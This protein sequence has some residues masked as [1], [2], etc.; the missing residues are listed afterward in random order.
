MR[1]LLCFFVLA[2][3]WT[4][5]P[6][7]TTAY[8]IKSGLVLGSQKWDN[9]FDR[10]ILAKY[11]AA[12]AIETVDEEED[13]NALFVQLGYHVKGS[14][15]RYRFLYQGG[16]AE[17]FSQE[18][19][20]NNI[21]LMVAAKQKKPFGTNQRLFYF[22]GIRGDYTLST[23]IDNLVQPNAYSYLIYP[24]IGG[25]Q[26][27]IFGLSLGGGLEFKFGELLGGQIELSLNPDITP[28]Y[29]Q[30]AINNVII[31]G[32]GNTTIPERRIKNTTLELSLGLRL[33]RKVVYED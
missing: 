13:K 1:P 19:H 26:R 30:A 7:Q 10:Q 23:N 15:T 8:V 27:F 16:G 25:V 12:I 29:K 18:F 2:C 4:Y 24:Y 6:A 17:T 14:A 22:G 5:L 20:F 33:L 32:Q 21:S 31:P 11:H 3:F 9:S 28:Q